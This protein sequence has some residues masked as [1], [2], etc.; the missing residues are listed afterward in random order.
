MFLSRPTKDR[1]VN[2][3]LCYSILQKCI[4]RCMISE[5]LYY[6]NLI[7]QDGSPNALRKRL[8]QSC[9]EDLSRL[10]LA[11][12]LLNVNDTKLFDYIYIIANN[13]KSRIVDWFSIVCSDYFHYDIETI[14]KEEIEG[15]KL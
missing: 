14:D 2:I 9:L 6:G 8:I 3:G 4:R 11:I 13:K 12:E 15:K 1:N 5:S 10:D 7:Y